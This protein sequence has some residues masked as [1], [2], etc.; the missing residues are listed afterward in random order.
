MIEVR[1]PLVLEPGPAGVWQAVLWLG[2]P[3]DASSPFRAALAEI[4]E[5][6]DPGSI[7]ELPGQADGEDFVEGRLRLGDAEIDVCFEHALG[8]LAL[9][10]PSR[11]V[12][13]RVLEQLRPRVQ[14]RLD[15]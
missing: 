10:S 11:T 15:A 2:A 8:Y 6:L 3:F 4:S 7:L 9:S 14:A 13:A 1:S 5:A 12:I